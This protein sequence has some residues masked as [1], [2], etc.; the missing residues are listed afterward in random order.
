MRL[1][2]GADP[3]RRHIDGGYHERRRGTNA[4]LHTTGRRQLQALVR[5]RPGL[6]YSRKDTI[7][8][9]P[10]LR[11]LHQEPAGCVENSPAMTSAPAPWLSDWPST[12]A[13]M[14]I[15]DSRR[16]VFRVSDP[17]CK[18]ASAAR[19]DRASEPR[20]ER[21]AALTTGIVLAPAS[22]GRKAMAKPAAAPLAAYSAS[23]R[24]MESGDCVSV[25]RNSTRLSWL[26]RTP[27]STVTS[28]N[29]ATTH[30]RVASCVRVDT[31]GSWRCLTDRA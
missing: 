28:V 2:C 31:G 20:R 8:L 3:R 27:P 5:Q 26:G 13:V 30:A 6:K 16:G 14:S 24:R 15:R 12:A 19:S 9:W 7:E 17:P 18:R 11:I 29:A 22:G 25:A 21:T 1:S 4:V 10:I 23:K